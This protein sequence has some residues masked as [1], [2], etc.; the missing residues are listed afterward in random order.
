[1][2]ETTGST[3][4]T[5]VNPYG[6]ILEQALGGVLLVRR[7]LEIT[8]D[9]SLADDIRHLFERATGISGDDAAGLNRLA[10]LLE[11]IDG[12]MEYIVGVV[13]SFDTASASDIITQ[14]KKE[15]S[16]IIVMY[17][18]ELAHFS[19]ITALDRVDQN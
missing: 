3:Y 13:E 19:N 16:E 1:M 8:Y 10:N 17:D 9:D 12:Q 11:Q 7:A 14:F 18:L 15:L 2:S 6:E 4:A 5:S